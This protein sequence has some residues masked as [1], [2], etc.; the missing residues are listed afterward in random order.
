MIANKVFCIFPKM[1]S[2]ME[3]KTIRKLFTE[4]VKYKF[5]QNKL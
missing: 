1:T 2:S 5:K 4:A 3:L